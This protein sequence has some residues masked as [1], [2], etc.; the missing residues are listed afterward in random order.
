MRS[1]FYQ[2]S[3]LLGIHKEQSWANNLRGLLD[4]CST[5][6]GSADGP[7]TPSLHEEDSPAT[8]KL[9]AARAETEALRVQMDS[10]IEELKSENVRLIEDLARVNDELAVVQA[11][12]TEVQSPAFHVLQSLGAPKRFCRARKGDS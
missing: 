9:E 12:V 10:K 3:V 5:S 4:C 6:S 8:S 1:L 2:I 11:Q 7:K